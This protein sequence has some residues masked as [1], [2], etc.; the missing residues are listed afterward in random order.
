MSFLT[1]SYLKSY[2]FSTRLSF[3]CFAIL[4]S[5]SNLSSFFFPTTSLSLNAFFST[6]GYVFFLL[7]ILSFYNLSLISGIFVVHFPSYPS[8]CIC[9]I[10]RKNKEMRLRRRS[11][12][13]KTFKISS[14]CTQQSAILSR[15]FGLPLIPFVHFQMLLEPHDLWFRKFWCILRTTIRV[16]F[17]KC[18]NKQQQPQETA[19][20]WR[21]NINH[22][23]SWESVAW[24]AFHFE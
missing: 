22:C 2:L 11:S 13:P 5:K 24:I 12:L 7:F 23:E 21:S 9:H 17:L 15:L 16:K 14:K 4:W 19:T 1:V 18:L 20:A 6:L 10:H 8:L 3:F